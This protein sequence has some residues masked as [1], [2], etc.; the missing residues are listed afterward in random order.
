MAESRR[1]LMM[2]RPFF[3]KLRK[4]FSS[5][6]YSASPALNHSKF[7]EDMSV[8]K[9]VPADV[10]EGFFNCLCS[11]GRRNTEGFLLSLVDLKNCKRFYDTAKEAML[12]LKVGDICK[13]NILESN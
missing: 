3:Q 10:K 4:G 1:G 13:A 12:A 2:F 8:G 7:D 9:A 11:E 6:A 5:S